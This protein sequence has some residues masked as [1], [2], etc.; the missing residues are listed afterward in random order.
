MRTGTAA[1][2]PAWGQ[3]GSRR[4]EGGQRQRLEA[5]LPPP[6]PGAGGGGALRGGYGE[7]GGANV[8]F[9]KHTVQADELRYAELHGRRG[10][11]IYVSIGILRKRRWQGEKRAIYG[12]NY[13]RA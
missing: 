5:S 3:G 6:R 1:S 9:S 8:A 12:N 13:S 7:R 10:T 2:R 11:A 4:S